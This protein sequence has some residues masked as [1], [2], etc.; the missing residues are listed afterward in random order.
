MWHLNRQ[1]QHLV[2]ILRYSSLS[3]HG[4]H[5]SLQAVIVCVVVASGRYWS[6]SDH[7]KVLNPFFFIF[8][9][10]SLYQLHLFA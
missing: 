9:C 2:A 5:C 4:R 1:T 3:K 6:L 7:F 10:I 8:L